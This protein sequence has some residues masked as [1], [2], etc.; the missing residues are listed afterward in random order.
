MRSIKRARSKRVPIFTENPLFSGGPPADMAA[1]SLKEG[2]G[3]IKN[4]RC[5]ADFEA[6]ETCAPSLRLALQS[7]GYVPEAR[8]VLQGIATVRGFSGV[9]CR[10]RV[11][12]VLR[13]VNVALF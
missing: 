8:G 10:E 7:G 1:V 11:Y 4:R 3:C 2:A 6:P 13:Y 12:I 5:A 9:S